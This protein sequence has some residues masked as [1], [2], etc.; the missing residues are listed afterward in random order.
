M[1]AER[2]LLE[3]QKLGKNASDI[4]LRI[5]LPLNYLTIISRITI[6]NSQLVHLSWTRALS[7]T[8][9]TSSRLR[10]LIRGIGHKISKPWGGSRT[11]RFTVTQGKLP[12]QIEAA[13]GPADRSVRLHGELS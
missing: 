2:E 9:V 5:S 11:G 1:F 3:R 4:P 10:E 13:T 7:E 8:E 6:S 12:P